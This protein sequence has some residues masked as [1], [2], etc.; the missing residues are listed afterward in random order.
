MGDTGRPVEVATFLY[1][2]EAQMARAALEAEGV[3]A[4]IQ[5]QEMARANWMLTTAIGGVK[6]EVA[7]EDADRAREILARDHAGEA[8]PWEDQGPEG[9]GDGA[10]RE[11]GPPAPLRA[12]EPPSAEA[13]PA[14]GSQDVS[15]RR[16]S[17]GAIVLTILCLGV[18]ILVMRRRYTCNRCL[19]R[20]R[21]GEGAPPRAPHRPGP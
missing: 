21:E 1:V 11:G 2:H 18:P 10:A 15:Y 17:K 5:D 19:R 6:L 7:A 8:L 3:E 13:C 12:Q 14:C 9:F 20:W 4:F 16:F